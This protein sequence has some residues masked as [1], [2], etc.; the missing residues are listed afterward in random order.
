MENSQVKKQVKSG[1]IAG[2]ACYL[3]WGV[4]PIYW[5]FLGHVDSIEIICQ[6][7]IWCFVFTAIA[8]AALRLNFLKF[9]RQSRA[10]RYMIPAAIL[11]TINWSVFIYAVE[12]G[13]I[14]ETSLGYYINPLFTILLG[15]VIFKERLTPVQ[16]FAVALCAAGIA[17][18]SFSYG[19]IPWISLTLVLS[20]GVYSAVKKSGGYPP[21]ESIAIESLVMVPVTVVVLIAMAAFGLPLAFFG[22]EEVVGATTTAVSQATLGWIPTA[23]LLIGG[24]LVTATPLILFAK[25][26]ISIPL[27]VVGF[28]QF[29]SPTM[30]L[31]I[32]IFVYGEAFTPAHAVCFACIWSGL[33]LVMGESLVNLRKNSP[34]ELSE[35]EREAAQEHDTSER[36]QIESENHTAGHTKLL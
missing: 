22:G 26:A 14:I 12:I 25:A 11:I 18:F 20:F 34:N 3:L 31:L 4:L 19:Q 9:L 35:I 13:R 27:T 6:R 28:L 21:I 17:Y 5:K 33:A 10:R 8:C 24:G 36:E 30:S 2:V 23:L 29:I 7:I 15:L 32:G 16:W 1:I